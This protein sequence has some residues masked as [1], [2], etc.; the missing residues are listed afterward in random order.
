MDLF[1]VVI[2]TVIFFILIKILKSDKKDT[3]EEGTHQ[4]QVHRS[5]KKEPYGTIRF[6]YRDA[7][8]NITKRTV[9]VITGKRGETFKAFCHLRQEER[10][11]YF[12]RIHAFEVID[13]NSGEIITPMQ[14]R[15]NLQNTK[16]AKEELEREKE[17]IEYLN[18]QKA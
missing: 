11:F 8:G 12:C 10:S 14:W 2:V 1:T 7:E 16:V 9:D 13:V 6:Q 3:I 5:A 18:S 15:Y 17:Q 4:G